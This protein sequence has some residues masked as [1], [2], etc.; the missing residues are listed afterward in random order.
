MELG[1]I[2]IFAEIARKIKFYELRITKCIG[3]CNLDH[4][5]VRCGLLIYNITGQ[6]LISSHDKH[7][8]F[9]SHLNGYE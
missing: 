2:W 4:R 6:E 9:S 7:L 1:G 3:A 5:D 8:I